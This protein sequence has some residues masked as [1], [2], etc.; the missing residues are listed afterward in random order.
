[1]NFFLNLKVWTRM[2]IGFGLLA[3]IIFIMGLSW[4][5]SAKTT[6]KSIGKIADNI[7]PS[8]NSL[9]SM[10]YQSEKI[11]TALRTL[12]NPD[13]S[14]EQR[15]KQ[16]S[17]I[18]EARK[19]YSDSLS[20]YSTM[21]QTDNEKKQWDI[22][23]KNLAQW[24]EVNDKFLNLSI[25]L[26]NTGI[27]N[28]DE[29]IAKLQKF[30]GDHYILM[31]KTL[32]LILSNQ[33]FEG[34]ED[35]NECSFG[36]W[37]K[38][39]SIENKELL[40]II[41]KITE[42]HKIFH[43]SIKK[44]KIEIKTNKEKA[45][46]IFQ[47]E[48][49][50]NAEKLSKEIEKLVSVAEKAYE[51]EEQ[52]TKLMMVDALPIQ[53]R[54]ISSLNQVARINLELAE[55]SKTNANI[56]AK[57]NMKVSLAFLFSGFVFAVI[58]GFVV[59]KSILNPLKESGELFKAIS[60]GDLT[61]NVSKKLLSQ[62]DELGEMGRQINDMTISLRKIFKELNTGS[63]TLASSATELAAASEQTA[64]SAKESTKRA[65]IVAA[66]AEE[67]TASAQS[68]SQKM[69]NSAENLNSVAS[70]MEQMTSTITEIASNTSTANKNSEQ[71]VKQAEQFAQ[72]MKNL[73]E[74]ASQIGKVTE[75]ISNISEQTNLLAL[76]ATI[77]AARAGEA[78][79]GFAVVAGEIKELASQTAEATEDISSKITGI[80]NATKKAENDIN[81][82]VKGITQVNDIVSAIASA[83]EE[84][85]SA[86][87]EVSAN[88]NS[89][90]DMVNDASIQS[91]QMK[92][93]SGEISRDMA[94]V[95]T[96]AIQVEGASSQ[97][98]DTVKE[99][100]KL[101]EEIQKMVMQFKI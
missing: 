11:V 49:K 48:M 7:I 29:L 45:F 33:N 26:D 8:I 35:C 42:P 24:K 88:I 23:K 47:N 20:I 53:E 71:S 5:F 84:Q 39:F 87:S 65:E 38:N 6:T 37:I 81:S 80:Q 21:E 36:I 52:M 100:S 61:K 4:Y 30:R 44:I 68:M 19:T 27:L 62:K 89:A 74:S 60:E 92:N 50:P 72:I 58:F 14:L 17:L 3:A 96:S 15:Q 32:E 1:M 94:E 95:S 46:D 67:L 76:N 63:K 86:V 83:I 78:G 55:I 13:N 56:Q 64:Q 70:A 18:N 101:S 66:A 93:V 34:G 12:L 54:T 59:T 85:T 25:K 31:D 43:D 10:E 99:L 91:G 51:V 90:S 98:K 69:E 16:Y 75:T 9:S 28:P 41:K 77:E 57:T 2:T 79:R 22:F 82:I 73:G 40:S 97:V